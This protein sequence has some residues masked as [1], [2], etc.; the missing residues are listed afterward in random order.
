MRPNSLLWAEIERTIDE[1]VNY[2]E[3]QRQ[4]QEKWDGYFIEMAKL[5]ASK[6]C[7]LSTKVGCVIVGPSH[8][9]RSTGYNGL[10]RGCEPNDERLERPTKY[11][12]TEH[13]ERNAIYNAAR[14]GTSLKSC[15]AYISYVP[16]SNDAGYPCVDCTRAL[17]Q[18]GIIEIVCKNKK[19]MEMA[20]TGTWRDHIIVSKEMLEESS[21]NIRWIN[22]DD[23]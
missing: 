11:S 5:V 13:A 10:P 1:C 18:S 17:I 20:S 12:W 6:S 22:E 9:I 16:S 8:E 19:E 23:V 3:K 21:V 4:K 15:T 2:Q 7:D 14:M